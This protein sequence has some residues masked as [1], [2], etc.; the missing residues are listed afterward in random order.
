QDDSHVDLALNDIL[1][2]LVPTWWSKDIHPYET[3]CP[4]KSANPNE[5]SLY[6]EYKRL[7]DKIVA[8]E[9]CWKAIY[10][11]MGKFVVNDPNDKDSFILSV[12]NPPQKIRLRNPI[13][14]VD[15]TFAD[16]DTFN[17]QC[18]DLEKIRRDSIVHGDFHAGNILIEE[19][20]S[21]QTIW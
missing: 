7:K 5:Q 9:Q 21:A 2:V 6:Y 4:R 13:H 11:K 20:G 19:D 16:Q 12:G 10:T 8:L 14:W 3:E 18:P 1:R 17:L 15:A